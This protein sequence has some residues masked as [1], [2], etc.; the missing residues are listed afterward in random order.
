MSSNKTLMANKFYSMLLGGTLTM[1]VVSVLLMSDSIIAGAVIGSNAVAGITLVTPIYSLSAFV[2]TVFSLGIPIIYSREMGEFNKKEADKAFGFGLVM[3]ITGGMVLFLL[4]NFF[5]DIFLKSSNPTNAVLNEAKGYLSWMRFTILLL[6][7]QA[8]IAEMV[9]ND[10]DE[11]LSTVANLVQGLGNIAASVIL[12]KKMGISGIGLASFVFNVIAILILSIHF[13]KKSNSLKLNIY[14]S[15][16]LL[17]SVIRYSLIDSSTYLFLAILTSVLNI[18]VSKS[19]GA[20]Y[21]ILVSVV[22]LCREFQLVFDGIGE[23]ITPIITVYLGE[24]CKKGIKIIYNLAQKTAIVEGMVVTVIMIILAPFI[25]R[26]LDITDT[27]MIKEA[28]LGIRILAFGSTFISL[29]YLLTSYYLLIDKIKLGIF[30]CALRD[31]IASILFA[32]GLGSVFGKSGLFMG[33]AIAPVCALGVIL[34]Y[35]AKRY[36][37]KNCPIFFLELQGYEKMEIF[38]LRVEPKQII[39]VQ[40]KAEEFLKEEK[41]DRHSINRIKHLIEEVYMLILEK[42]GKTSPLSECSVFITDE[43]IRI[44]IKDDG[45]LF[46]VSK[47]DTKATSIAAFTV[48]AYMEKLDKNKRHL[49]TMSFNRSSFLIK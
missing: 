44:I 38:N 23:A 31:V 32:I 45:V 11:T 33:L 24:K 40:K 49:T 21:L 29:L 47:E 25:P 7:L 28:V 14:F 8:L 4:V 17:L 20:K 34:L 46:D 10:G 19:F 2:A 12:S 22:A 15:G 35:I 1:M 43:G 3:C 41:V 27:K 26:V 5:G 9:Y 42:N 48:S 16:K 37:I 30:V 39:D 6:P 13:L 36:G 18:Y